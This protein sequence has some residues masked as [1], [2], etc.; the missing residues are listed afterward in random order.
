[1][2]DRRFLLAV[3]EE[4]LAQQ[5]VEVDRAFVVGQGLHSQIGLL[6]VDDPVGRRQIELTAASGGQ[7]GGQH[8]GQLQNGRIGQ[9]A[10]PARAAVRV[11]P[12]PVVAAGVFRPG[13]RLP[14]AG[15]HRVPRLGVFQFI[16]EKRQP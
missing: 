11:G 3:Q 9:A 8:T 5:T 1:M 13:L 12:A 7:I 6:G 14:K 15:Q 2:R 10:R 4:I 16:V